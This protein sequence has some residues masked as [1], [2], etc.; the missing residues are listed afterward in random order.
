MFESDPAFAFFTIWNFDTLNT[1]Q[2]FFGMCLMYPNG[3]KTRMLKREFTRGEAMGIK[4]GVH[5]PC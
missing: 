5:R 2:I 1:V 4:T 3:D